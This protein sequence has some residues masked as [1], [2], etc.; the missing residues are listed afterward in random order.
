[1]SAKEFIRGQAVILEGASEIDGI[2]FIQDGEFEVTQ[3]LDTDK[4]KVEQKTAK[5]ALSRTSKVKEL[6]N[7]Q[8]RS[9][10]LLSKI[11]GDVTN[12][13][14]LDTTKG[15]GR[16]S[17][18]LHLLIL[19]KNELFGLDEIA[20]DQQSRMRTV[21]CISKTGKCY[22]IEKSDFVR[23]ANR[24][25]FTQAVINEQ[26]VKNKLYDRRMEQTHEFHQQ[27]IKI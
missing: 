5:K 24:F 25:K 17:K 19:G 18:T 23:C 1:M 14:A 27:I 13:K 8:S 22:F 11:D 12:V 21:T 9:R 10:I 2:Y 6:E 20:Q 7:L 16:T 15:I 4:T 26:M 3:K